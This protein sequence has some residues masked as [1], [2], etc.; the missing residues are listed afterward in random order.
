MFIEWVAVHPFTY[1][2]NFFQSSI[3][4]IISFPEWTV[5]HFYLLFLAFSVCYFSYVFAFSL[6]LSSPLQPTLQFFA[7]LCVLIC[8]SL[9]GISCRKQGHLL[10]F[11]AK[12]TPPQTFNTSQVWESHRLTQKA[13]EQLHRTRG[14]IKNK[15]PIN[16]TELGLSLCRISPH[17]GVLTGAQGRV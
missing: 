14:E 4:L 5:S 9:R 1:G 13:L 6:P 11:I 16:K 8:P 10:A 7:F 3:H 12:D 2:I 15:T 17:R